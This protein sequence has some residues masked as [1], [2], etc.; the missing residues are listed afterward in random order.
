MTGKWIYKDRVGTDAKVSG[1]GKFKA[2]DFYSTEDSF[3][4]LLSQ[5]MVTTKAELG[6]VICD[7]VVLEV[8]P[9]VATERMYHIWIFGEAFGE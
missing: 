7:R 1:I 4:N 9:G 2:E 6:Y 3:Y 5:K 8:F